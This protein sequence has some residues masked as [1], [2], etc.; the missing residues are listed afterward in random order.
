[1]R[2]GIIIGRSSDTTSRTY[3]KNIPKKYLSDDGLPPADVAIA[4]YIKQTYPSVTVDIITP[5]QISLSRLNKCDFV[6]VMY[7]LI[8]AYNEGG[9]ELF[10]E[11]TRIYSKTTAVM[12]PTVPI[13][14]LI[15]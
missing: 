11:R 14:K 15:I 5:D 4:W 13:Q 10:K 3:L 12:Y 2:L 8:D 6:Y 9:I 1:M 7:D